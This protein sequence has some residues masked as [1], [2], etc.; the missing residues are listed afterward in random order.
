MKS[1]RGRF[2]DL[3]GPAENIGKASWADGEADGV[4]RSAQISA[5]H[6]GLSG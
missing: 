6:S 5:F 4:A 3:G 1:I 2:L